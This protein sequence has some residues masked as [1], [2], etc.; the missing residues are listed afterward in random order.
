MPESG[1][2]SPMKKAINFVGF[3][4]AWMAAVFGAAGGNYW[5]GP[6]VVLLW[7]AIHIFLSG[8]PK[9]E[10]Q[11]A[12]TALSIGLLIDTLMIGSGTYTPPG[13]IGDWILPPPWML[14]LWINFGTVVNGSLSWLKGR[15]G[16]GGFLGSLGGPAAY[17]SGHRLGA[18]AFHPP[19]MTHLAWMA[20][21]WAVAVPLLFFLADKIE[22]KDFR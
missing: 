4:T 14:A 13:L 9:L 18:L 19:L 8:R 12:L 7:L 11:I 1:K 15:Y 6:V 17:F 22:K 3:Q 5:I 21:A 2:L 16:L 10:I 20:M